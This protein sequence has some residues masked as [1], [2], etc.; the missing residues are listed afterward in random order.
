[1]EN[2]KL[3]ESCIGNSIT[4]ISIGDIIMYVTFEE[5]IQGF[6]EYVDDYGYEPDEV[7]PINSWARD[8]I[9]YLEVESNEVKE[10]KK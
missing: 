1:M 5:F 2:S 10:T 4:N 8:Y 9:A 6:K 3:L 7:R